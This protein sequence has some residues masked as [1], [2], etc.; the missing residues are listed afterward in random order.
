MRIQWSDLKT[1][2]IIGSGS[3]GRVFHGDL[4]GTEVAIKECVRS[5]SRA[6][7]EK[8]FKREVDILKESRHP[9]I[10]QFMGICKRKKRFYIVTEFLPLGNLRRWIQD[11]TKEF[12]WDTRISFAIDISLALAYLHHKN[13]IH[14]DLKGENLLISENM[15]I[16]VCDFGFSRV[17]ARD[18]DEMRRI[19]YC[20]TDGYMAPEILL[21]EDFDCSVDVFSF[22][23]V[24]AEMMARHVV[25]PQHFQR[26]A[27]DMS[28]SADE[29]LFRAQPGC[30]VE[31]GELAVHCVQSLPQNRPKL[32][33]IVEHLTMIENV[34]IHVGTTLVVAP[35]VA[36]AARN[37]MQKKEAAAKRF[38]QQYEQHSEEQHAYPTELQPHQ[39]YPEASSS[40]RGE[41]QT[42][43]M[44]DEENASSRM[45]ESST[46]G[47]QSTFKGRRRRGA[48]TGEREQSIDAGSST[49]PLVLEIRR[50][51]REQSDISS[52][53]LVRDGNNSF[54][55]DDETTFR[56]PLWDSIN[57]PHN[58]Q[59][60]RQWHGF[61][62]ARASTT[63]GEPDLRSWDQERHR[64][65]GSQGLSQLSSIQIDLNRDDDDD[66]NYDFESD[67]SSNG[68]DYDSED[69]D[70]LFD[71]DS[72]LET[73]SRSHSKPMDDYE[74]SSDSDE[75]LSSTSLTESV[76][77][78]LDTLEIPDPLV[79]ELQE[80]PPGAMP[81]DTS[82]GRAI[83]ATTTAAKSSAASPRNGEDGGKLFRKPSL[84]SR[85]LPPIP[86]SEN[87][88]TSD[89]ALQSEIAD[90]INQLI[91]TTN[92][93]S[94][95]ATKGAAVVATDND[96]STPPA[97]P[98]KSS[99][100]LRT[101]T[102]KSLRRLA[103]GTDPVSAEENEQNRSAPTSLTEAI[104]QVYQ[105]S[106]P[107]TVDSA[108]TSVATSQSSSS[109]SSSSSSTPNELSPEVEK[110]DASTG[111]NSNGA[112]YRGLGL[113]RGM[114][115]SVLESTSHALE[116]GGTLTSNI[117]AAM[118]AKTWTSGT[119]GFGQWIGQYTQHDD[120]S[121][122]SNLKRH[123]SLMEG[124]QATR[125]L[126]PFEGFVIEEGEEGRKNLEIG[127]GANKESNHAEPMATVKR[128]APKTMTGFPHRF[129]LV[130]FSTHLL[131][132]C[133]VCQKRLGVLP[134]WSA[135]H[136]ECDDCGYKSHPKCVA[137]VVKCC[138]SARK[139]G[140]WEIPV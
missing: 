29:I 32:R 13:I 136:L 21:G 14:R 108:S 46:I 83:E 74:F 50:H 122:Q 59:Q 138:T 39:F 2:D 105:Q 18:D 113:I 15:R 123:A 80:I 76:V 54:G 55:D 20:G 121:G 130:V 72:D 47:S 103:S 69:Q 75:S 51:A 98:S 40:V 110:V 124:K 127:Q 62:S 43:R 1:F 25:D 48:R 94:V 61:E 9:N 87:P 106:S 112:P 58:L 63:D 131:P 42:W 78:A 45:T 53:D 96:S 104:V 100:L 92:R 49:I 86:T 125:D 102:I 82:G 140:V 11:D 126:Q 117:I 111:G 97:P 36:R 88:W 107:S 27:P 77:I 26:L 6:F 3:F 38:Q 137:N 133:D 99:L 109:S 10:V 35:S 17:E 129:S 57:S 41:A 101:N 119:G 7:D 60:L 28:V 16:K 56:M 115:D 19:S 91:T 90:G 128:R 34:D 66:G 81:L 31:L 132:K 84:I 24:L 33:Q 120:Q 64:G 70:S 52:E 139:S 89:T 4:L 8:Y 37:M 93:S 23:I 12:G 73:H 114:S 118:G 71:E 68:G 5:D 65:V 79:T 44:M 135:K 116:S 30:P 67:G 85:L 95:D 22:G 134:G